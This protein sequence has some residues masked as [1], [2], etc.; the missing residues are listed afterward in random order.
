VAKALPGRERGVPSRQILLGMVAAI[1]IAAVSLPAFPGL[2]TDP[3]P[4][5]PDYEAAAGW[6]R[7]QSHP[8]DGVVYSGELDTALRATAYQLRGTARPPAQVYV[9]VSPQQDG[10]YTGQPCSAPVVCT[11]EAQRIWLVSNTPRTPFAGM[12]PDEGKFLQS[13]Y[14]AAGARD[15]T[16]GLRITLFNRLPAKA[17]R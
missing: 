7:T 8:G 9:T 17:E 3:Q 15:F 4:G 14:K 10:T 6:L 2:R 5:Q 12:T 1:G 13:N 11:K 16:G